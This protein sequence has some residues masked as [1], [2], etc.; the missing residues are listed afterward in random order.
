VRSL[1]LGWEGHEA[2]GVQIEMN[3]LKRDIMGDTGARIMRVMK[4]GIN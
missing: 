2:V 4:G 3:K 1:G